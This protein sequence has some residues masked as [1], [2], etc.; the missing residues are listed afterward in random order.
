[1]TDISSLFDHEFA[2]RPRA[3]GELPEPPIRHIAVV[4]GGTA[5][6]MTALLL[7]SSKFG[8]RLKVTVLESPQVGII[9][10]GEGS[11]PWLRKFF[12]AL[13][14]EEREWMPA[15]NATYKSGITFDRWSTRPGYE[16]YFHPFASILD[17]LT[18][19]QF[20]HLSLIHI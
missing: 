15:C 16:S 11:T 3:T 20:V 7:A 13:G 5:G 17:N 1:M 9:G 4:G 18:M 6:W 14:I 2:T 8:E 19:S 10:V 12:E